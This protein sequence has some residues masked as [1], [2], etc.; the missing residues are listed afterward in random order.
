MDRDGKTICWGSCAWAGCSKS[1]QDSA[2]N[3]EPIKLLRGLRWTMVASFSGV[4]GSAAG[5]RSTRPRWT[6]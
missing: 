3:H 6:G 1:A 2:H 4:A 5:Q